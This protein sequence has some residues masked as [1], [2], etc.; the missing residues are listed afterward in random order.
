MNHIIT[1]LNEDFESDKTGE[2][3]QGITIIIDGKLK[4]IFDLLMQKN[5]HYSNYT[6]IIKD[7]LFNGVNSL[8]NK[9]KQ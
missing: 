1:I 9:S 3:V 4:E 6:E 7:A 8:I 5:T 2:K